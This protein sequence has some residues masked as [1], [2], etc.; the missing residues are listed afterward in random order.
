MAAI[1][2]PDSP[3]IGDIFTVGDISYEWTGTVWKSITAVLPL[4][5]AATHELG[6]DDELTID[7][8]QIQNLVTDSKPDVF[9][10]M[11]A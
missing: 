9:M 3:T 1:D 8:T 6:G 2:F 5:H 10:L 7:A 11:G 4:P